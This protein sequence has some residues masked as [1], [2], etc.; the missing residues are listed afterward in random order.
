M[1]GVDAHPSDFW[2][3]SIAAKLFAEEH[4]G[5]LPLPGSIPD[6]T[7]F[8]HNYLALQRIYADRAAFE[9]GEYATIVDRVLTRAGRPAGAL[10]ADLLKLYV[11]NVNVVRTLR[12]RSLGDEIGPDAAR[13]EQ[14]AILFMVSEYSNV[15]VHWALRACAEYHERHGHFPGSGNLS[16]ESEVRTLTALLDEIA[17]SWGV[18]ESL[19]PGESAK[20]A[21]E[22]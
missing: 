5:K 15:R 13:P 19:E 3:L 10:P 6:M 2:I 1:D 21:E 4:D 14:Y 20:Y 12:S 17:D 18:T 8:T 11:R 22:M 9:L 7:A 16:K